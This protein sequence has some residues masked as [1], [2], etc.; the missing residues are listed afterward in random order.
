MGEIE[1]KLIFPES[2]EF[3]ETSAFDV[4]DFPQR[5]AKLK[6]LDKKIKFPKGNFH[7]NDKKA[8]ALNS[9]ANHELLAIEMM[10]CALLL[11]PHETEEQKKAKRGIIQSLKDEQLHLT[12][13]KNRLEEIGYEFGDFPL[14]DF[15]WGHMK[16]LK[17]FEQYFACMALTFEAA[18]LDF[19]SYFQ[20]EFEKVDD[21][22]TARI[23]N[24]V[25]KDEISHV[26][27]GVFYLNK[28]RENKSLWD[29]YTQNLNFP[30]T[31]ARSKGQVLNKQAR[32]KANL[33]E[34][35]INNLI[36]FED[37]FRVTSRK[38]WR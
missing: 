11:Y 1:N 9:F 34:D 4:P 16:E 7:L 36:N 12:L 5:S 15:F 37:N 27:L 24:Q 21:Q 23:L 26:G 22:K 32:L 30:L 10:A 2:I 14:S 25:L 35:F 29:Y 31:P 3:D 13:Y 8:I 33:G 38:Q 18:N 28:W 20:G 17:T 6:I 19:A